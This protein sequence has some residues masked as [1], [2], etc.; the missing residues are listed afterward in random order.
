MNEL[1]T[2]PKHKGKK[3]P[4]QRSYTPTGQYYVCDDCGA[5]ATD[6]TKVVHYPGCVPGDSQHWQDYYNEP[7]SGPEPVSDQGVDDEL[8]S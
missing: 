4:A 2:A 1:K 3:P 7:E 5:F 8:P 6:P